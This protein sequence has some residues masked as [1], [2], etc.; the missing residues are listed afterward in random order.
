MISYSYNIILIDHNYLCFES[1]ITVMNRQTILTTILF[2]LYGFSCVSIATVII[3][4]LY[5]GVTI[6]FIMFLAFDCI[7]C[8]SYFIEICRGINVSDQ[9]RQ[10]INHDYQVN[11]NYYNMALKYG[12]ASSF[13]F[14]C[15]VGHFC[16]YNEMIMTIIWGVT[17]VIS[18]IVCLVSIFKIIKKNKENG[19][20]QDQ[21]AQIQV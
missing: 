8:L 10:V 14:S 19:A 7:V 12:I 3:W 4:I 13:I 1:F 15:L 9:I 5:S 6:F 11:K 18:I 16:N 17:S 2:Y 20:A 21:N